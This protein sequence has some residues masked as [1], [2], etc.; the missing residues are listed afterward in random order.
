LGFEERV[1]VCTGTRSNIHQ[2]EW[3]E[4][5]KIEPELF[6]FQIQLVIASGLFY[7]EAVWGATIAA[8]PGFGLREREDYTAVRL[9]TQSFGLA[10]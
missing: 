10:L 9:N 6:Y 8:N 7:G 3:S 2:P 1:T 4:S 5:T